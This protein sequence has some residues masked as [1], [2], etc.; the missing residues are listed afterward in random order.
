M[1]RYV[2]LPGQGC[3]YTVRLLKILELRQQAIDRLGDEFDIQEFHTLILGHG[4]VP[5]AILE[6]VVDEWIKSSAGQ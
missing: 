5:L 1:N 3:G 4:S 2:I 6:R